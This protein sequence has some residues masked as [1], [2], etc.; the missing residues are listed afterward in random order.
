MP[1]PTNSAWLRRQPGR[2]PLIVAHR[3]ASGLAPENTLAAFRLALELGA[4]A[5]ECDVHLS[6]DGAPII[7]HDGRIDRTT[8]GTGEVA[9]LA[10]AQLRELDAGSWFEPRFADERLPTLSEVLGVAANRAHVFVELKVGGGAPLVDAAL[11]AISASPAAATIISFDPEVVR[12]V[13]E[14]RA[15]LPLGF[16]VGRQH[17]AGQGA[18]AVARAAADL[19]AGFISPQES[20]V[21]RLFVAE[22]HAAGLPVSVWTVD[23]P[24]RMQELAEIG[25]DAITTNRPDV[26]LARM[27]DFEERAERR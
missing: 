21:D 24:N 7:I 11:A 14:R 10:L 2:S 8:N 20:T 27:R 6:A 1:T 25:V 4:P 18:A 9:A 17:V 19:G 15:D 16:L 3:G 23:D 13:A 22:A 26:A 12:L 5:I